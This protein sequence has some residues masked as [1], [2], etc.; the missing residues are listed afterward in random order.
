MLMLH[1]TQTLPMEAATPSRRHVRLAPDCANASSWSI[2]LPNPIASR[3][4]PSHLR[5]HVVLALLP[6]DY[7]VIDQLRPLPTHIAVVGSRRRKAGS[8]C[9]ATK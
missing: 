5:F 2:D 6:R 3:H 8:T 9:C 7:D 1:R 4:L